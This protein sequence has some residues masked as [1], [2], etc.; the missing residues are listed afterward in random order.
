M[1]ISQV[2]DIRGTPRSVNLI[3]STTTLGWAVNS[4]ELLSTYIIDSKDFLA[5]FVPILQRSLQIW[6]LCILISP[7]SAHRDL[8]VSSVPTLR[9][10][11]LSR[12][13]RLTPTIQQMLQTRLCSKKLLMKTTKSP[14]EV[15][16]ISVAILE[17]ETGPECLSDFPEVPELKQRSHKPR[18]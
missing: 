16:S 4:G 18:S 9:P 7:R 5:V 8:P 1:G 3:T 17:Q 13:L 14:Y 10:A 15:A 2:S 12:L 11:L 6:P